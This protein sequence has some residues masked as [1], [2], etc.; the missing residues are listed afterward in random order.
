MLVVA[1]AVGDGGGHG[2][3]DDGC[4]HT[5]Q[6]IYYVLPLVGEGIVA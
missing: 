4:F 3:D 5:E 1:V 6:G 2:D